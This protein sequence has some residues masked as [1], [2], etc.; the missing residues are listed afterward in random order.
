M[1][2]SLQSRIVD[3]VLL[4]FGPPYLRIFGRPGSGLRIVCD[5]EGEC[6]FSLPSNRHPRTAIGAEAPENL[7]WPGPGTY[8]WTVHT[9]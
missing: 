4:G 6:A 5:Y 7:F 8:I 2:Q 9:S 3:L 1:P